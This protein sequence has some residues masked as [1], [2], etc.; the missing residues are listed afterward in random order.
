MFGIFGQVSNHFNELVSHMRPL[1]HIGDYLAE[2]LG[3]VA[4]REKCVS[5]RSIHRAHIISEIS[6][7][8]HNID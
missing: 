1:L 2:R 8:R 5:V 4:C 7:R 3:I 6:F